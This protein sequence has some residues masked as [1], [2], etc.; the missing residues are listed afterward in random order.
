MHDDVQSG[1]M[2]HVA[3]RAAVVL[4]FLALTVGA[5]VRAPS[6]SRLPAE[7]LLDSLVAANSRT[8]AIRDGHLTG[9]GADFL[10]AEGA[11]AQF[12]ALGEEHN[13]AEI[14]EV[15]AALLRDLQ[16]RAGYQYVALEQDPQ[17]MRV[18]SSG[19]MRG[20]RDSIIALAHR[21][22][23]A[24]TFISDQELAMVADAGAISRGKGNAIW[25]LDQAFG[26]THVLDA[27]LRTPGGSK[28]AR[29]LASRY[30]AV[31]AA[32]EATR[33]LEKFHYMSAA[34]DEDFERLAS[35]WHAAPGSD[36][37]F[38]L[39]TL[40]VSDRVYRNYRER[41]N[42]ENGFEREEYMKERFMDEYRHA[43]AADHAPPKV[44]MKLGHWHLYRG[45]S[46]SN[47]QSLGNFVSEFARSHAAS[48]FHVAIHGNNA[49]GGFRSLEA[50]PD[51]FP[52]PRIARNLPHDAWTIVDLRP[53]RR[54]FGKLAAAMRSDQRDQFMRLVFGF[55][56][57][58]YLGG[59]RPATYA[60]NPGVAY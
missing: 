6:P 2:R 23:K 52:D 51:S 4:G 44:V 26:V 29:D 5:A 59:M 33:D 24:F 15:V 41:H 11:R 50:W 13:V 38:L 1:M 40:V 34:K 56:A 48:T 57:A 30:R 54:N 9:P 36:A 37:A 46:P 31:A 8:I 43:E 12:V 16:A 3:V 20:K 28:D 42:Y 45:I 60:L 47:M 10:L 35:L 58:L 14:P 21:Y 25:G 22:Q 53:L 32:K 7:A 19:A 17:A 27:L 18:A 55:D 39:N 49:A